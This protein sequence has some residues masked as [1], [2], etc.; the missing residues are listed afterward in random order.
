MKTIT[1]TSVIKRDN[2]Y[3]DIYVTKEYILTNIS[4]HTMSKKE[5]HKDIYVDSYIFFSGMEKPIK[6]NI[7]HSEELLSIF[8]RGELET[9]IINKN[10]VFINNKVRRI[11][12]LY[13]DDDIL[14][15][16]YYPNMDTTVKKTLKKTEENKYGI[17]YC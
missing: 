3:R 7:N 10:K 4:Y 1:T 16:I 15:F 13:F 5:N 11:I 2:I 17:C 6:I 12:E 9:I 14:V 8:R